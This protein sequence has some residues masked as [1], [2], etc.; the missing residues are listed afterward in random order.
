MSGSSDPRRSRWPWLALVALLGGMPAAAQPAPPAAGARPGLH[1]MEVMGVAIDPPSRQSVVILRAVEDKR[2]LSI[3]IGP[4]E[5]QAIAM[6]LEGQRPPRPQTFDLVSGMLH[7]LN[8]T[9]LR[10]VITDLRDE[11][12]F[13]T[14]HLRFQGREIELDS[15]PSDALAL[16]LRERASILADERVFSRPASRQATGR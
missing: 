15:R 9:V 2:E 4:Q 13:A 7:Q 11:T 5:A 10:V 6:P 8:A 14:I 16:A 3:L 12:Y 1:T